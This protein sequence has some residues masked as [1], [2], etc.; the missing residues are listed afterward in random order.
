MNNLLSFF[1]VVPS[2]YLSYY[3]SHLILIQAGELAVS[4]NPHLV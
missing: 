2:A 3:C 4:T 1:C